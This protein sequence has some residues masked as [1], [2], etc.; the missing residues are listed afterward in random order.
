MDYF[1]YVGGELRVE[2]VSVQE[3][4][5]KH[6]TPVYIYSGR[7]ILE[8]FRKLRDAFAG[9]GGGAQAPLICYSVKA[10]SNLA[11]L[12]LFSDAG[13]GF[14]IVSHGEL[15]RVLAAGG[16][17]KKVVFSG[18]GKRADEMEAALKAGILMFNVES[19]EELA[20]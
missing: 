17:P 19:A 5:E 12:K 4:A 10:N 3:I 7:T 20:L 16:D 6:G 11:V 9:A 15:A 13:S 2:D 18:V 8:H 14:D 1:N